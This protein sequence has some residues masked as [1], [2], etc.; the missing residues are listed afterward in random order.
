LPF[1]INFPYEQTQIP[2]TNYKSLRQE[3][4]LSIYAAFSTHS[5][6]WLF[7][8]R[9]ESQIQI[10]SDPSIEWGGHTHL[11]LDSYLSAEHS[12]IYH[13]IASPILF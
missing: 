1:V 7:N 13:K 12:S 5:H 6:E 9:P 3:H 10:L 4:L 11:P 2:L 8:C